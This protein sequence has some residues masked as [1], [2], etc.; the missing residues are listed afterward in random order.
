METR[1]RF[2]RRMAGHGP[3]G[4]FT[5]VE[6]LSVIVIVG[7]LTAVALPRFVTFSA[8]AHRAQ[9]AGTAGSFRAAI[10]LLS[11]KYQTL[12]L[13]GAQLNIPGYGAGT[14]DVNGSGY[15]IDTTFPAGQLNNPRIRNNNSCLNIWNALL[16]NAPAISAPANGTTE[17]RGQR[18]NNNVCRFTYRR[19]TTLRR[20]DYNALTGT[21]TV[22]NP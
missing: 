7:I 20:F 18:V 19:D 15:P 21:V 8:D 9:V 5:L 10:R 22:T 6:L 1:V 4:G 12:G 3:M 17:W 13:S 14:L 16:A 11:I 2:R